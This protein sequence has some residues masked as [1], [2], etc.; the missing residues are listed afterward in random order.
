MSG[1]DFTEFLILLVISV[2]VSGILHFGLNYF[3]LP[4][5]WSF[6]SKIVVGYMG[7]WWGTAVFGKWFDGLSYGDTYYLPAILGSL[8]LLILAVDLGKMRGK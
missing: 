6:A 2:V 1:M 4:G 3:V 7:A 8:A 5:M